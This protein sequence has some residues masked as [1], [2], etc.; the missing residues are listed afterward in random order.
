MMPQRLA[1]VM[2]LLAFAVCLVNGEFE[3]GN[4]FE[5]TVGRALA[6]MAATFAVALVIGLMGQKMVAENVKSAKEKLPNL[7]AKQPASDR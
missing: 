2:A 5:T 3:A 4:P 7:E 1:A 6:A